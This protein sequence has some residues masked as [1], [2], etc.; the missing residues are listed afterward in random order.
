MLTKKI[1]MSITFERLEQIENE[2]Q[3][4]TSNPE[5]RQWMEEL[6]VGILYTNHEPRTRATEMMKLWVNKNGNLNNFN[7]F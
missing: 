1:D 7:I 5:F 2:R 6:K 3:A 4:T